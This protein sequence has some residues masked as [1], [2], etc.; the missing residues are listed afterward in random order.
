[1]GNYQAMQVIKDL[2]HERY[3]IWFESS[4]NQVDCSSKILNVEINSNMFS[5]FLQQE[6]LPNNYLK[7]AVG[8]LLTIP[9]ISVE[10]LN[11]ATNN[12]AIENVIGQGGYG[13]VYKG[14][15]NDEVEVAI[16][17]IEFEENRANIKDHWVQSLNELRYLNKYR[18]EN[19]LPIYGY[20]IEGN[21]FFLVFKL[22]SGGSLK[23]RLDRSKTKLLH[24]SS[25][26]KISIGIAK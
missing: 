26:F 1:M 11:T 25:R 15:W 22:M 14:R 6:T 16:K 3:H 13:V 10:E 18:H 21:I 5:E 20:K 2:V 24:W 23:D 19:I 9:E 7:Q 4:A 8:S 12:W 17:K